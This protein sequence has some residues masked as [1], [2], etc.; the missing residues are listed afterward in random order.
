MSRKKKVILCPKKKKKKKRGLWDELHDMHNHCVRML[1]GVNLISTT[2]PTV[3]NQNL[4]EANE[5]LLY[6]IEFLKQELQGIFQKHKDKT[7]N[8]KTPD[9]TMEG[10]LHGEA[11][12]QWMTHFEEN[13]LPL[14]EKFEQSL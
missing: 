8:I 12:Y 6:K 4:K 9:E 1:D 5:E 3:E 13:I 7:G 10:I 14:S 2:L 11:Y